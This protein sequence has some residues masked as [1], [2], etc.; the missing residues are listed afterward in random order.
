[1]LLYSTSHVVI[2]ICDYADFDWTASLFYHA[3]GD[4]A[5]TGLSI[6]DQPRHALGGVEAEHK[7]PWLIRYDSRNRD[8]NFGWITF[9]MFLDLL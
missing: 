6:D 9:Y 5:Q 1:M 3:L 7:L 8:R 2:A 4:F